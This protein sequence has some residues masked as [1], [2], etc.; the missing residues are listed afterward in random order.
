MRLLDVS[1]RNHHDASDDV[2]LVVVGV[3][4]ALF[5]YGVA[6]PSQWMFVAVAAII[7]GL[8]WAVNAG[9]RRG[10]G[11]GRAIRRPAPS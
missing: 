10:T 5:M 8:I 9:R 3:V 11:G 7:G 2:F 4:A 6:G 1:R